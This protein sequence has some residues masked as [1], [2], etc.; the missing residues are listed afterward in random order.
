MYEIIDRAQDA[1]GKHRVRVGI[2]GCTVMFKFDDE[3]SDER[4]QAEAAKY[5]AL[6]QEL[7]NAAPN[8]E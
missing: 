6:M 1:A 3:P 5:D 7:A 8:P 2:A 4:V